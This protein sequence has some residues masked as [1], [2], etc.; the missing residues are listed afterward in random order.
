MCLGLYLDLS[1][2]LLVCSRLSGWV[3]GVAESVSGMVTWVS[4]TVTFSGLSQA[5]VGLMSF[6]STHFRDADLLHAPPTPTCLFCAGGYVYDTSLG[7][8]FSR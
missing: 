6:F 1:T 3:L 7:N 4:F 5:S 8:M 2:S